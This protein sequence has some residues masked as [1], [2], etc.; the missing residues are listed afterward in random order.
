MRI[1]NIII[2]TIRI[3]RLRIMLLIFVIRCL[4]IF[5]IGIYSL[6][7]FIAKH[8][9]NGSLLLLRCGLTIHLSLFLLYFLVYSRSSRIFSNGCDMSANVSDLGTAGDCYNIGWF[10]IWWWGLD[11]LVGGVGL[12]LSSVLASVHRYFCVSSV[13]VFHFIIIIILCYYFVV[14]IVI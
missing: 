10:F 9:V 2:F 6:F 1:N 13:F 3:I 14:E 12:V 4:I 8:Y 11:W 7:I 5:F